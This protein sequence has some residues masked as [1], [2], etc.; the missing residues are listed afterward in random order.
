[1][2]EKLADFCE[3]VSFKSKN[4]KRKIVNPKKAKKVNMFIAPKFSVIKPP[5]KG[6]TRGP[7]AITIEM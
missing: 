3:L 2:F 5:R 4:A 7:K 6:P 1:M